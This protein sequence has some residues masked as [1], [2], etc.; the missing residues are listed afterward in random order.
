MTLPPDSRS[1]VRRLFGAL[2]AILLFAAGPLLATLLAAAV[3]MPL[4]CEINEAGTAPCVIAGVDFG[5]PL[6][7]LALMGFFLIYTVPLGLIF[8]L[9]WCIAAG[10]IFYR[11][12]R[13]R[14]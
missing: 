9:I 2:F 1:P 3:A 11:R 6:T 4:G 7:V 5:V 10:V 12:S 13:S 8:L 14:L